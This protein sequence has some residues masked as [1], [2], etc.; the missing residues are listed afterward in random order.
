MLLIILMS[1][2][3]A[4]DFRE[5]DFFPSTAMVSDSSVVEQVSDTMITR[6]YD[7]DHIDGTSSDSI[8]WREQIVDYAKSFLNKPYC[9]SGNRDKC[10]DCSGF[11]QRVFSQFQMNLPHSSSAQATCGQFVSMQHAQIG[12]LIFF[13]GRNAHSEDI[14]HVGI[15]VQVSENDILFIH[16]S[17]KSGVVISSI[18]EPYYQKRFMCIKQP[19]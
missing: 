5:M 10:F 7:G 11:V 2:A 17:V 9:Y 6:D 1:S 18:H 15:V 14:G 19:F 13:N 12:D 8:R 4:V 3:K 16:S